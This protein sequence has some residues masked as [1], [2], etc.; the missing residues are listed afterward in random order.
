MFEGVLQLPNLLVTSIVN[1][2]ILRTNAVEGRGLGKIAQRR[3][4]GW[5]KD[6]RHEIT[7]NVKE[8]QISP[9]FHRFSRFLSMTY[10][11]PTP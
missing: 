7:L 4:R 6:I 5:Q 2:I 8:K 9:L 10:F 11:S 3:I 1:H